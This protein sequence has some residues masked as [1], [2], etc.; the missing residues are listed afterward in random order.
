[1]KYIVTLLSFLCIENA[2]AQDTT[3]SKP[4]I[5]HWFDTKDVFYKNRIYVS[6]GYNRAI[7]TKSDIHFHGPGYDFTIYG[8]KAHDRPSKFNFDTYFNPTR[9]TIPQYNVR[10]GFYIK[11]GIHLSVGMDHMK[12]VMDQDQTVEMSGII[13]SSAIPAYAGNYVNRMQKLDA[14]FLRFEHTNGLNLIT[15][16]LEYLLPIYHSRRDWIH[17]GWNFGIGGVFVVTKTE[18]HIADIGLDNKFH[19]SGICVPIKMGP[20]IDIWRYFFVAFEGKAGYMHLPWVPVR[21]S[22]DDH[23]DHN[24]SFFEYYGVV[25]F[26]YRIGENSKATMRKKTK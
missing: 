26:S 21:N 20:R 4:K 10:L 19:L 24:F 7:F 11:N 12:Y 23:I 18:V 6:W 2:F 22:P 3:F 16:E 9:F 8:A 13:D 14:N 17:I 15:L 1:M 5:K 25:G